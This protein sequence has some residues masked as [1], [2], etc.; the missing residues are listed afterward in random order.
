[1]EYAGAI[2]HVTVR[3]VG[4]A[5]ESK[6]VLRPEACLFRDDRERERFLEQLGERVE[7]FGV[8]LYAYCLMLSHIHLCGSTN[9][10]S[11]C[12]DEAA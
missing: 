11:V 7:I 4:D 3:M 10:L 8:G 2:Y 5:W 6:R 9:A 12:E 1:M